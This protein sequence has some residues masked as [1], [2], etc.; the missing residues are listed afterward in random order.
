MLFVLTVLTICHR[1]VKLV[2]FSVSS[3]IGRLCLSLGHTS[4]FATACRTSDHVRGRFLSLYAAHDANL[5]YRSVFRIS[6]VFAFFGAVK[7]SVFHCFGCC[8]WRLAYSAN[9]VG[10]V[11]LPVPKCCASLRAV[12]PCEPSCIRNCLFDPTVDTLQIN[13]PACQGEAPFKVGYY[14]SGVG[15]TSTKITPRLRKMTTVKKG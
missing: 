12:F 7:G 8:V 11:V 14:H 10:P 1:P 9:F 6:N 4:T 2:P 13:C 5:N 3:S 15:M